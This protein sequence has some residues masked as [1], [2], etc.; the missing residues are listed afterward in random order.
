M[1]IFC[2]YDFYDSILSCYSRYVR[3]IS[4]SMHVMYNSLFFFYSVDAMNAHLIFKQCSHYFNRLFS[5]HK[6]N[7]TK[8]IQ[9]PQLPN[10][11]KNKIHQINWK[12]LFLFVMRTP[13]SIVHVK[14]FD[15]NITLTTIG[16]LYA[17]IQ[18]LKIKLPTTLTILTVL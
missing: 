8:V 18:G 7:P 15:W 9:V 6:S 4:V 2:F 16:K 13:N 12:T 1:L 3:L 14:I 11:S 5:V 10:F 17:N